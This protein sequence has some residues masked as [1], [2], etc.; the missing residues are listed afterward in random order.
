[1]KMITSKNIKLVVKFM[2]RKWNNLLYTFN[3]WSSY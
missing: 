3:N 2:K 1:M